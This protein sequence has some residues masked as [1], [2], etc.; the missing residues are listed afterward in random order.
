M[1]LARVFHPVQTGDVWI[2]NTKASRGGRSLHV[3]WVHLGVAQCDSIRAAPPYTRRGVHIRVE[4]FKRW[5]RE[6]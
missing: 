3:N 4:A 6:S 5:K 2:D 1:A